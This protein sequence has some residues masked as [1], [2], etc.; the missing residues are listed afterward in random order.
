MCTGNVFI[1]LSGDHCLHNNFQIRPILSAESA[2]ASQIQLF[3]QAVSLE[4]VGR[5]FFIACKLV[6]FDVFFPPRLML[7]EQ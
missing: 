7:K 3:Y 2:K 1:D 5:H 4:S 6:A